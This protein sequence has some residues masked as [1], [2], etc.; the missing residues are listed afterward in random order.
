MPLTGNPWSRPVRA[1]CTGWAV[2]SLLALTATGCGDATGPAPEDLLDRL[3]ALDGVTAVEIAPHYAYPRA[4]RLDIVQPVDHRN[5]TGATF[6]QRA[7]LSHTSEEAPMVFGAY[8]YGASE[9]SGEEMA[10][11]LQANGVYVTHRFFPGSRPQPTD[12][13]YLD[14][15]QAASDH[16]RIVTLLEPIYR[17][18]WV[19]A[20]AS[21]SGMTPL[22]HRRFYPDDVRATVAYVSPLMFSLDD[23]RF[24]PHLAATGTV[25]GKARIHDFQRRLLEH[26][27]SLL[28]RFDAWFERNGLTLSIPAGPTFE[29]EVDSYEWSFWQRHVFDYDDI[30]GPDAPYDAWIDHLATVTRLHFASDTWRDYFKAYVYQL[31][32]QLGSPRLDKSHLEGLLRFERLDPW[33][34][35]DFPEALPLP[36][37]DAQAMTD[38]AQWIRTEGE[39]IV[40]VYGGVDPWTGGAIDPGGNPSVLKVI[41]PGADHQ[42]RI[43]DL[44]RR[45]EVL[46]TL[47]QWLGIPLAA[48]PSGALRV[49][50]AMP[51]LDLRMGILRARRR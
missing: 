6:T 33:R 20:G 38:V 25:E 19:S 28:W 9:M 24:V 47:S 14:I 26:E 7:Y 27:D 12:W 5:P 18:V 40:L 2:A 23:E 29:D 8:G 16:H 39:R 43:R 17:G 30:P 4:F 15:W 36:W 31:Y 11:I 37:D 22:F 48:A 35:Y 21:K 1:R 13:S 10:E 34:E 32:T 44:D 42:V 49:A 46:S 41:Q 45:D 50:P 51:D 3:N